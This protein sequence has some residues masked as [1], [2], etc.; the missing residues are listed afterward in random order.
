[1][2]EFGNLTQVKKSYE[3]ENVT[4]R[5]QAFDQIKFRRSN[6]EAGKEKAEKAGE[7]FEAFI[8]EKFVF[9]NKLV[10]TLK[11]EANGFIQFNDEV[12]DAEGK[13]TGI[14]AVYLVLVDDEHEACK[15]LKSTKKGDNKSYTIKAPILTADLVT[16]GLLDKDKIGS[17]F[18]GLEEAP[19]NNTP[20]FV[21]AV[22]KVVVDANVK[23]EEEEAAEQ[24]ADV[25]E[26]ATTETSAATGTRE[27]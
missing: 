26:K 19:S 11:L 20:E 18:L 10:D 15:I 14:S 16:A 23:E 2:L 13:V 4:P 25:T 22:Y 1:M 5:G 17:Q 8:D 27:F 7:T 6:S 21:K 12:K 9:A 24:V 3:K